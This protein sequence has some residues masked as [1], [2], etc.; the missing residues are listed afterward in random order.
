MPA[1]LI[2]D[3]ENGLFCERNVKDIS[4]KVAFLI[5]NPEVLKSMK[6]CIRKDYIEKLGVE[7]QVKNWK[8][9][10]NEIIGI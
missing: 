1:Y 5:D 9:M 2:R 4:S 10:F 3:G 8:N 7:V 6:S